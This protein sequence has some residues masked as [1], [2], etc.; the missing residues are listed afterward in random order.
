MR[1]WALIV[2]RWA[3]GPSRASL[4]KTMNGTLPWHIASLSA[5]ASTALFWTQV[6]SVTESAGRKDAMM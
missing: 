2:H 3:T 4:P 6:A 5:M 1:A